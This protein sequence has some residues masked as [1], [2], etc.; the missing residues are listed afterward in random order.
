MYLSLSLSLSLYFSLFLVRSCLLIIL[1]ECLKGH[2]SLMELSECNCLC[3]CPFICICLCH[4]L[5]NFKSFIAGQCVSI[6]FPKTFSK[7]EKS[8]FN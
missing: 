6:S 4:C 5:S 3:H 1:I 2:K 8:H 7:V